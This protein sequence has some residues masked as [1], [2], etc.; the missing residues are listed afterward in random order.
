[1]ALI[2]RLE[3]VLLAQRGAFYPWAPVCL[4]AGIGAYFSVREEPALAIFAV[5]LGVSALCVVVLL[6][7]RSVY[8]PL[9]WA[10]ALG[11]GGFILAGGKA[12]WVSGPVLQ[13]HYYGPVEGRI[14]LMD[15]SASGAVRLT[16][17]QVVLER[18]PPTKTP[19]RVRVALHGPEATPQA[20]STILITAH[21]SAPSG[22]VEPGGFDFQRHAW[23]MQ[24]GGLG[25]SRM[26]LMLLEP[27]KASAPISQARYTF[28]EFV[29]S[30]I[31][32]ERGAFAATIMA[33]DRSS[34]SQETIDNLRHTNLAHLLAISGLHMGLLSGFIYAALRYG[35]LLV[36]ALRHR[37]PIRKTAAV[38]ALI[39]SFFY[40]LLSGGSVATER[41]FIMAMVALGAVF[42]ERRVFSLRSVATA[43]LIVLVWRPEA[44]LGPGFQMSFAATTALVTVFAVLRSH[45]IK[46]GPKWLRPF[47]AL[48][49]TST[50]A[51]LATAPIAAA[52]F[53]HIAHYGLIANLLAVPLMG[54]VVIPSAVVALL[55]WPI[56]LSGVGFFVMELGIA[57][58]LKVAAYF[59]GLHGARGTIIAPDAGVLALM[60]SGAL[61]LALWQGKARLVGTVP[62]LVS[63]LLWAQTT[64][65]DVLISDD[66]KLVGILTK[67][68]RALSV[69]KGSGFVAKGWLENDGDI[70]S[71]ASAAQGWGS[72][73]GNAILPIVHARR[74][75]EVEAADCKE[76]QVLVMAGKRAREMPCLTFDLTS[77]K[78]S[79]AVAIYFEDGEARIRTAREITGRRLWTI[80]HDVNQA[81]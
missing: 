50:V 39:V 11:S 4:A 59:A 30:K 36:P 5:L 16:L 45:D 38:G 18:M 54:A 8:M 25:Y 81:R 13:W 3:Q 20:G 66:G 31:G 34:M 23:F 70:R 37:V 42:F 32:G 17:D 10:V 57:W 75:S 52:H 76:N 77:L 68:G 51:G 24:I 7:W 12:Y 22:P 48:L 14:V 41:A 40:L 74:K 33:G 61:V 63:V 60:G 78:L 35:L 1:M 47:S 79:G 55:L 69:E 64:R 9:I 65:P 72:A 27:A 56:G 21:L 71:Q 44:L 67:E 15:R 19:T 73:S 80:A 53:N 62:M 58:I 43:A 2:A 6:K 28:S 46:L 29:R 26:P 49:I